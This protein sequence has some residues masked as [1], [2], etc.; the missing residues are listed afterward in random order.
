M[1][2][3]VAS[4]VFLALCFLASLGP[5]YPPPSG[6]GG[7]APTNAEYIVSTADG[8]LSAEDVL[9]SGTNIALTNASGTMTVAA[10]TTTFALPGDISPTQL[11]ADQNDWNPT[12]LATSSVI[13]VTSD[14]MVQITG[15]QGGSDGR[16]ITIYNIGNWPIV[17]RHEDTGSSTAANRFALG[18]SEV[19]VFSGEFI[20]LLYDGTSSRWR[21]SAMSPA[22]TPN[23]T[24]VIDVNEE[25]LIAGAE[26]GEY[27]FLGWTTTTSGTG[28]FGNITATAAHPGQMNVQTGTTSGNNSRLHF[29]SAAATLSLVANDVHYWSSLVSIPT[30]TTVT[31]RAGIGADIA[32]TTF[33]AEAAYFLFDPAVDASW[34]SHIR[35]GN[36]GTDTDTTLDVVANTWYLLEIVRSAA[37]GEWGFYINRV[38]R[39]TRTTNLPTTAALNVGYFVG[40]NAAAARNLTID[41]MRL[42]T[43]ELAARW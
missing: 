37:G 43:Q 39:D 28:V 20:V 13:R 22:R 23:T 10:A 7:G 35:T 11:T 9:T 42:R 40:T 34:R 19:F 38:R 8:T 4:G 1:V 25:F 24:A 3:A 31:I 16:L 18:G 32:G 36:T 5:Y 6:G 17:I 29:G 30:I 12:D 2:S 27:G 41:L 15:L 21:P 33:G 14:R 26:N